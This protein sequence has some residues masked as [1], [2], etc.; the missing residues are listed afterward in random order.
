VI[1]ILRRYTPAAAIRYRFAFHVLSV[2]SKILLCRTPILKERRFRCPQCDYQSVL[3][4]S[5]TDRN[6]PQCS[7][8]RRRD[9]LE[10]SSQLLLPGIHYF[11]VIFTLPD[12]LSGLILGNRKEL[13]ALLFRSAWRALNHCL[14]QT[15]KYHPAAMMV[16]HT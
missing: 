2:L 6:C 7:G 16:L 4:N 11:Q 12:Q 15:G 8:A 13:Y 10:K 1:D 9:W 5:C 3:Y 14:R